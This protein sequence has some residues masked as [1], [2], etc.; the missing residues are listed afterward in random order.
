MSILLQFIYRLSFGMA[1]ATALVSP[2]QVPSGY[3]R[4]QT[5]VLLGFNVLATLLVWPQRYPPVLGLAIALAVLSY[6]GSVAWLYEATRAARSALW[7]LAGGAGL[8]AWLFGPAPSASTLGSVVLSW[9]DP[10]TAGLVLGATTTAMLL[11][12]WYLNTPTMRLAPLKQLVL[13]M[14]LAVLARAAVCAMGLGMEYGVVGVPG[15]AAWFLL[16]RWLAG[17]FGALLA[18]LMA[19]QT[20]KIPNTQSATGILYVGVIVTFIGEL[21]SELLS[22]QTTFPL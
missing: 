2:R 3:F 19:W 12:H 9:L 8:A 6:V 20:L 17:I 5:Y 10:L 4:V 11:G 7:L 1:L 18:T 13:L 14:A 21:T 16:L 22:R 15:E